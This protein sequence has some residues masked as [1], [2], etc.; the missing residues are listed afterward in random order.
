M[1]QIIGQYKS[2]IPHYAKIFES[3]VYSNINR[4][5]NHIII[6]EQHI[7]KPG[8][9]TI[10]NSVAFTIYLLDYIKKGGQVDVVFTDFKKAFDTVNH[11]FLINELDT[12]GISDPLFSWLHSY[13][14]QYV[15]LLRSAISSLRAHMLTI[16]LTLRLSSFVGVP[17][18]RPACATLILVY[19]IDVYVYSI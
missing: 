18:P 11:G 9:S 6:D 3:L 2:I 7:F 10:T 5:R 15:N 12:L 1:L 4:S 8:K 19:N 16:I 17:K 14:S 13:L